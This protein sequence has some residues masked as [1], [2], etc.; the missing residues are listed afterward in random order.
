MLQSYLKH[1]S[2]FEAAL[3]SIANRLS[4]TFLSVCWDDVATVN[5]YC[6]DWNFRE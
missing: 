3:D 4:L 2:L 5:C 6:V 1:V